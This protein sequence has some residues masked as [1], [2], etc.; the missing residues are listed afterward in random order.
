MSCPMNCPKQLRNGPCG[1]VRANGNCEVK[2]N[3]PCVWVA[4][5]RGGKVMRGGVKITE[6]QPPVEW[7]RQGASSWLREARR[8]YNS[9]HAGQK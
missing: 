5:H 9:K 7:A 8:G 3:M 6:V 2:P 1:G 4:A